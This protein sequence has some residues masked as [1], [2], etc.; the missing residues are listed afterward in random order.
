MARP[1]REILSGGHRYQNRKSKSHRVEEI[2]FNKDAR[3]EFL[4]GFHKRKVQ[5]RKFA[6]EMAEDQAKQARLEERARIREER[7]ERVQERLAELNRVQADLKNIGEDSGDDDD[8]DDEDD[9]QDGPKRKSVTLLEENFHG[10]DDEID[11]DVAGGDSSKSHRGILK[12]KVVYNVKS[13]N[14]P[15][16]GTSEVTIETLD[17][18]NAVNLVDLARLNN[19]DVN[20]SGDV[21]EKSIRRAKDY[22]RLM[23]MD[24]EPEP[25][26]KRKRKLKRKYLSKSQRRQKDA[27]EK[28]AAKKRYNRN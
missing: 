28:R 22:A 24:E 8:D 10:F 5:R 23:G 20:K 26:E 6:Q 12:Q 18:P 17:D 15:V 16:V 2:N 14:A 9:E 3:Q 19:V 7:R 21:L 11:E 1:N 4:T 27:K 13:D 25:A